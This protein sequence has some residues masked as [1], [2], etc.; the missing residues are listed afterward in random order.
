MYDNT[1]NKIDSDNPINRIA[2]YE[3]EIEEGVNR[4]PVKPADISKCIVKGDDDDFLD[5]DDDNTA[6]SRVMVCRPKKTWW[7]TAHPNKDYAAKVGILEPTDDKEDIY[8]VAED[9]A[10]QLNGEATFKWTRL[11]PTMTARGILFL[12]SI[13]LPNKD[14]KTDT[15]ADSELKCLKEARQGWRR[16]A[17]N[18]NT[19][20]YDCFRPAVNLKDPR[21]PNK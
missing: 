1:N 2:V 17:A 7:I 14:G 21:W 15:W 10:K 5:D 16:I 4:I 11:V 19:S 18:M 13:R 6:V 8:V 9:V 12:W 20:S 3:T